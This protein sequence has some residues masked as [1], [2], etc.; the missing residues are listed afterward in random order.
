MS[1]YGDPTTVL[2]NNIDFLSLIN[3]QEDHTGG[4]DT[5]NCVLVSSALHHVLWHNSVVDKT[6][7]PAERN[8]TESGD[9]TRNAR[10]PELHIK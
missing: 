7:N 6:R 4:N 9:K 1:D 8:G 10:N 2:K 5:Y 3:E